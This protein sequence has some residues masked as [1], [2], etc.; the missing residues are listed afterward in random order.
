MQ[1]SI[2]LMQNSASTGPFRPQ[3]LAIDGL[4][5]AGLKR[6]DTL[7]EICGQVVVHSNLLAETI[8]SK[9]SKRLD[10]A[11]LTASLPVWA[12]IQRARV[13]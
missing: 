1:Y 12:R 11:K 7:A 4:T 10:R 5:T 8:G 13:T 2:S 6:R 3:I 9:A